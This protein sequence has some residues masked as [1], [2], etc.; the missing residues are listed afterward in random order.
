MTKTHHALATSFA[1]TQCT[2]DFFSEH[3][4]K[5]FF[6]VDTDF[7]TEAATNVGSNDTNL[8]VVEAK[9]CFEA[10]AGT[11][12][13]LSAQPLKEAAIDPSNC[14][15]TYF[16]W[17]RCNALVNETTFYHYFTVCKNGVACVVGHAKGG[18]VEHHVA[19]TLF[20]NEVGA[21]H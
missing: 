13:V 15:T 2:A 5:H 10:F 12:G 18:G 11:L 21:C 4:Q 20:V 17:A 1:P 7:G 19:A 16:K 14:R 8:S 3:A 6:G 9:C